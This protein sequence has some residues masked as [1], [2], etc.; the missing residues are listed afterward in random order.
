MPGPP[1]VLAL[2][3]DPQ[4]WHGRAL[5]LACRR[6]G[7]EPDC[8]D[9][10]ASTPGPA[11]P[12][13]RTR[14]GR[15]LARLPR[16]LLVRTLP[17]A[18][19]DP[20][21]ATLRALSAAGVRVSHPAAVIALCRDKAR[22]SACLAAAGVATPET[23]TGLDPAAATRVAT[24]AAAAGRLLVQ[25]PVTGSGGRGVHLVRGP[26]DLTLPAAADGPGLYLQAFV[27]DP[28]GLPPARRESRDWRLYV[29]GGRVIAAMTRA[30]RDWRGSIGAGAVPRA[31]VPPPALAAC[32][33][34]ATGAVAPG[35]A[36]MA[37]VDLIVPRD[38]RPLVLEVNALAAWRALQ[39][40][41][42]TSIADRLVGDA[43]A[44]PAPGRGC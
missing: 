16:I 24:A 26:A 31:A 41:T 43:L 23:W 15:V 42:R 20:A 12:L 29:S 28:P 13:L 14:G 4:E 10:A 39:T 30:G 34:A 9:L 35:A 8:I 2:A 1:P 7:I 17:A 32:A 44:L 27:G 18:R 40:V 37:G 5:L 6:R 22:T 19:L 3:A 25:K 21:L 11:A 33:V 36:G 38:G